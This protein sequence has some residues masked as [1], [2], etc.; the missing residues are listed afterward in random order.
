MITAKPKGSPLWIVAAICAAILLLAPMRATA[1]TVVS[2]TDQSPGGDSSGDPDQ[3]DPTKPLSIPR[4]AMPRVGG[5]YGRG[6]VESQNGSSLA[7]IPARGW[8]EALIWS[9]RTRIGW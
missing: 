2:R 3:P 7:T 8:L 6:Y 4:G 9:L 1:D 5:G